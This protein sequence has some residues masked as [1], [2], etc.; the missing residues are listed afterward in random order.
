[1]VPRRRFLELALGAVALPQ[2]ARVAWSQTYPARPVRLILGLA[3]G[4]SVDSVTRLIAQRLSER[5]GQQFIIE[6]RVG[7]AGEIATEV[8]ARSPADGYTLL[9]VL[10]ANAI[11][12]TLRD[13][14]EVNL[15][16]D[17]A[18]IGGM[19]RLPN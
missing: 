12:A 1:M 8:V 15:I 16:R 13:K 6:N 11:N 3:P 18:L 14:V 7:A 9:V 4:G 2:V 10:A 17:I 19:V 5:L